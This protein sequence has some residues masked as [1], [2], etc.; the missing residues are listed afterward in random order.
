MYCLSK[1][2]KELWKFK[3]P[4]GPVLGSPAIVGQRTFAAGCDSNLHVIDTA[5]GT[6]VGTS[7]DLGG[8]VGATVAVDGDELFVGTM[9][10]EVL[11][12]N[13]KKSEILWKFASAERHQPFFASPALTDK[14]VIAGSR[15]KYVHALDRKTG[16]EIWSFATRNKV[17]GSP[18][19]AGNRV[20]V[21]SFDK[22]LYVLDLSNG[23]QLASFDLG[24]EI[25]ATPAV[26]DGC[27]V[28][29]TTEGVVYCLG[30]KQ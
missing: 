14:L 20:Y 8:Q 25:A 11:G 6:E 3:V 15:D 13:W 4:G 18:V 28:I 16:R 26:A 2:G 12:I 17:D 10:S 7:V 22:R 21:G 29:G 24:S 19:I 30:A 9:S 5:N 27:L 1:A 23:S